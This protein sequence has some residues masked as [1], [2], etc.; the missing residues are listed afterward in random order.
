[1][2]NSGAQQR[3]LAAFTTRRYGRLD[4]LHNNVGV[5]QDGTPE[6]I[7]LD[8]WNQMLQT[9]LTSALVCAKYCIPK[10]REGGGGSIINI[11]SIA[12][13]LGLSGGAWQ[14]RVRHHQGRLARYDAL[15]CGRLCVPEHSVQLHRRRVSLHP[16]GRSTR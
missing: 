11:S 13:F 6:T 2:S 16:V 15:D 7:E 5:G 1:H 8:V 4:I 12:G 10:M 9:N 14:G 3:A